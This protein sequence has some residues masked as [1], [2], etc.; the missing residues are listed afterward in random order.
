MSTSIVESNAE[1]VTLQITIPFRK[2]F[3]ETEE[4]IQSVLNEAG[5]IASGEALKQFD[6]DGSPIESSGMRWTSKG[7]LPK[8]YQTPYGMV[9]VQRHVYQTSD[10]GKTLCPLEVDARIIITST[11]KFAQQISHKY[12]Q[13][14]SVRVVEDLREN[15]GLKVHRS[16]V[17][18]LAEAV[19][20]IALLKE[21][22]WHYQTPKLPM[23]IETVS[24]GV[25]GT[26]MLLCE[27]GWRQAM[28]GTISLYDALGERQHTTYIAAAPEHG[29]ETFLLRMQ[30]EVEQVK[31]LY[32][33]AHYQG[34]ADGA[35]ENWTFL[36]P[37]THS[38]VLD[39]YH[40]TQYLAKV[41]KVVHPRST[42]YQQAWMDTHCHILKHEIGAA[43]RLLAEM[44]AIEP[45]RLSESMRSGLE[46]AITYF[47]HHHHQM[48]YA[49]AV[50]WNLPI[51]SGVTESAC[52]VIV[53]AR[54][55][56]AGMKWKDRGAGIVLSLRTLSYTEGRWQQFWSKINR[57]GFTLTESLH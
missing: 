23:A 6:T 57:Y 11:P 47:R 51:G 50:A 43:T 3:L 19:G 30:R 54:L 25:D 55:C 16:F 53:K 40:A 7:R 46:D 10:G 8:S 36:E 27:D 21:E 48:H 28:V 5:T 2:T 29:R 9:E 14:S 41:A 18:T 17:Q 37:L 4:T 34:L 39:F 56:G 35:A 20:T 45:K 32:P 31:R 22:D 15:H 33:H 44:S 1:F 13:M 49:E 52:K 12:A 26:C 42:E 38:Q 24:I